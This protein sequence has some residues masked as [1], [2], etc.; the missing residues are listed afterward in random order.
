MDHAFAGQNEEETALL[1]SLRLRSEAAFLQ[2]VERYQG[3]LT[4]IACTFV[5]DKAIAQEVVQET[6]TGV[7]ESID[8]FEVRSSFRTWLFRILV[9]K[10]RR[11]AVLE[12]RTVPFS[13]FQSSDADLFEPAVDPSR[14]RGPGEQWSGDWV[15]FPDPWAPSLEEQ[16]ISAE[17]QA[18][19]EAIIAELPETYRRVLTLRD[20][21][22]WPPDEVCKLLEL[23]EGNQRVILHRA[24]SRVR[25]SIENEQAEG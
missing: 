5:P 15:A 16:L 14:F 22:G 8:R 2:L 24:R 23:S 12:R 9:N 1:A 6:W 25:Q 20:I 10:A 7:L 4:R 17:G 13:A 3:S 21:E 18:R 11:R 19:L